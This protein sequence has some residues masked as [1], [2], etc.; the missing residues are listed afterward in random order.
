MCFKA[1]DSF[2]L[3]IFRREKMSVNS[4]GPNEIFVEHHDCAI[5]KRDEALPE[6]EGSRIPLE[7]ERWPAEAMDKEE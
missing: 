6:Q 7:V 2:C 1:F 5:I 4:P 3:G